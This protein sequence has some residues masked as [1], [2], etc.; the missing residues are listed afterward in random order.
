MKRHLKCTEKA[1]REKKDVGAQFTWAES[2]DIKL[3]E[4]VTLYKG[5]RWDA[6]AVAVSNES[7]AFKTAKQCRERWHN[8]L[9][10]ALT[11]RPWSEEEE[12]KLFSLHPSVGSRRSEIARVIVGRTDNTIKNYFLCKLRKVARSLRQSVSSSET[13]SKAKH[14]LYLLN[15]IYKFYIS[16]ES[17]ENLKKSITSQIRGRKNDGDKYISELVNKESIT[18]D[19]FDKY[20]KSFLTTLSPEQLQLAQQNYPHFFASSA[21]ETDDSISKMQRTHSVSFMSSAPGKAIS[22]SASCMS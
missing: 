10:P 3:R 1:E 17:K 7:S 11:S 16:P 5:K 22:S 13:K 6:V 2:E 15:Y 4:L 19:K 8:H 21:Y 14:T 20:L 12:D 18:P 9:N